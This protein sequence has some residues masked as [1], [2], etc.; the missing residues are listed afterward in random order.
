MKVHFLHETDGSIAV[1]FLDQ[2]PSKSEHVYL[3]NTT[4][5]V[6]DAIWDMQCRPI[7]VRLILE[8]IKE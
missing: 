3:D 1:M 8:E 4:Y 5:T 2:I 6:K 7:E